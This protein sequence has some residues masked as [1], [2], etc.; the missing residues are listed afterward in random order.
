MALFLKAPE[1]SVSFALSN[2]NLYISSQL[3]LPVAQ[4]GWYIYFHRFTDEESETQN[5]KVTWSRNMQRHG[6]DESESRQPRS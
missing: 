3:M 5:G 6:R 4:G 1:E 2:Y